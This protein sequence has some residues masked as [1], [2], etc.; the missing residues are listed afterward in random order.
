MID[1]EKLLTIVQDQQIDYSQNIDM[2]RIA[3]IL[4]QYWDVW[5]Y[6]EQLTS[7]AGEWGSYMYLDYYDETL[8]HVIM[9]EE[10]YEQLNPEYDDI[11][12]ND[13]IVDYILLL[14]KKVLNLSEKIKTVNDL[15]PKKL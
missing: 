4:L 5:F 12:S 7:E 9:V 1:R 6:I 10:I 14:E 11:H 3:D 2:V 15:S 13:D 8:H